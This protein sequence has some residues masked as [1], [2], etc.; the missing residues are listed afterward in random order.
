[1][2]LPE[3]HPAN[4][5]NAAAWNGDEGGY[6]AEQDV[7]FNASIARYDPV[8]RAA[9][10]IASHERV[11]DIGCGTGQTTRDA[12]R[13]ARDGLAVGVDVSVPMIEVARKRAVEEG[14]GNTSFAA[15]DAQIYPFEQ[16][17]FDV[18]I[19]RLG[20][21]FFADAPGAFTNIARAVQPGGRL[22]MLVWQP[23]ANNE[24]MTELRRI[25]AAG[26]D[27][28]TPPPNAPGP[29][30]F[31]DRDYTNAVLTSAGFTNVV[32]TA[33]SEPECFGRTPEAAFAFVKDMGFVRFMLGSLDADVR[34][35]TLDALRASMVEHAGP[36][37]VFYDSAAWLVTAQRT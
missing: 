14:I 8:F 1:V 5:E 37:G 20:V 24:W 21:M 33:I 22:A 15:G 34:T 35:R 19:S 25:V 13:A 12:A 11:L 9:A 17:A 23:M 18:V 10:D 36:E 16:E 4:A 27:L 28:P 6:W 7:L 30:A 26:R 3:I 31:A 32:S 29:F 2:A